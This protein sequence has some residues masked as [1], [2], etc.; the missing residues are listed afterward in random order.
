[1]LGEIPW[2]D[3]IYLYHLFTQG[4]DGIQP[5][6]ALHYTLDQINRDPNLLPNITLGVLAFDS[7]DNIVNALD[8]CL[9]FIKGIGVPLWGSITV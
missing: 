2:S 8:Q 6:E 9:D 1:M 3:P 7:C 5:L 4:D